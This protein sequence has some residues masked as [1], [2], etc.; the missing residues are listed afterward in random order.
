MKKI[1][2][3]IPVIIAAI[4]IFAASTLSWLI[5]DNRVIFPT[6]FGG[7]TKTAYFAG[8]DGSKD[9]PYIISSPVHFYNL[10]WLQYLGYF[11]LGTY[12]NNGRAQ[13][14]FKLDFSGS[15]LNMGGLA[16]PPIGTREYPFIGNFYGNGKTVSN[17]VVS[18][19]E[20]DLTRRPLAAKFSANG[21]RVLLTT[22][23]RD[24][25]TAAVDIIGLFGVTGDFNSFV[26]EDNYKDKKVAVSGVEKTVTVNYKAADGDSLVALPTENTAEDEFYYS[27]MRIG[28]FYV[29]K[30]RINSVSSNALIGLAAGYVSST[31]ENVGVYRSKVTVA[32]ETNGGA[33]G[34]R[35]S[36][37]TDVSYGGVISN[38]SIVGD[39]DDGIVGWA[40]APGGGGGSSSGDDGS[41]GGSIDM[42]MINRRVN[43]MF[44]EDKTSA[45]NLN[46]SVYN[47]T[48]N[49]S[50]AKEEYYWN[51]LSSV[52]YAYLKGGTYLPLNVDNQ[53]MM[54]DKE[55]GTGY[56][57]SVTGGHTND[58]YHTRD[59]NGNLKPEIVNKKTNSGYLV[60]D[61]NGSNTN[62]TPRLSMQGVNK[63]SNSLNNAM[64]GSSFDGA[65]LTLLTTS[66]KGDTIYKITPPSGTPIH[67]GISGLPDKRPTD[68]KYYDSV[69]GNFIESMDGKKRIHGFRLMSSLPST[70]VLGDDNKLSANNVWINGRNYDNYQFVKGCLNFSV[71]SDDCLRVIVGSY[72][73][74]S[75]KHALF[76]LFKVSRDNNGNITG[77]ERI[78]RIY[79]NGNNITYNTGAEEDLVID[80]AT[81]NKDKLLITLKSAYYFEIPITAGDYLIGG[82]SGSDGSGSFAAYLMYLDIG[83][84]GQEGGGTTPGGDTQ[85]L[86]YIMESVDFV[87]MNVNDGG[88][89]LSVPSTGSDSTFPSYA[90]VG[91]KLEK[92]ATATDLPDDVI[93]FRREDYSELPVGDGKIETKVNYFYDNSVL[94]IAI[95]PADYGNGDN[96]AKWEE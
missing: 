8:G 87:A 86:P 33:T 70:M 32:K 46:S 21:V 53:A 34:I 4:A 3:I 88:D 9:D 56:D 44:T 78:E 81:I 91:F 38:Y 29:D 42:K 18:N 14:F 79:R 59:E 30:I 20:A 84:N 40:E 80:L 74:L 12:I 26:T 5:V 90:D 85:K 65:N 71:K 95:T 66:A 94:T 83:A 31:V 24:S 17:L 15:N 55:S 51:G 28:S 76:D 61:D 57:D 22:G 73:R 41:W 13:S 72:S 64:D 2:R 50:S 69:R 6:S 47:A 35:K 39:Y 25:I 48:I 11:N 82:M 49:L 45:D 27:G 68:F 93:Y 92:G 67:N 62:I 60:G 96:K 52:L 89:D 54:L 36:S 58:Y 1:V 75:G 16:I 7:S 19:S 43:Y 10:A 77:I 63:I 37:G 23:E